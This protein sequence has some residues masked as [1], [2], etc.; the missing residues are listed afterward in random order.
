MIE[1]QQERKGGQLRKRRK[2]KEIYHEQSLLFSVCHALKLDK[3][4]TRPQVLGVWRG[5]SPLFN[6][7]DLRDEIF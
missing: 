4:G 2:K 3:S 6:I 7:N 1:G 5:S